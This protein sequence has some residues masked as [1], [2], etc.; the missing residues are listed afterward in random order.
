MQ[1]RHND[2]VITDAIAD[3]PEGLGDDCD[4]LAAPEPQLTP[5][6]MDTLNVDLWDSCF[7]WHGCRSQGPIEQAS[8]LEATHPVVTLP[9]TV[10]NPLL[11]MPG[12][13]EGLY[14]DWS[15]ARAG[16]AVLVPNRFLSASSFHTGYTPSWTH[17]D[18]I[19][20]GVNLGSGRKMII[21]NLG[22]CAKELH[23]EENDVRVA[24]GPQETA[25]GSEGGHG[26]GWDHVQ[27]CQGSNA[28]VAPLAD[29]HMNV[30]EP[31]GTQDS[32]ARTAF[33]RVS[34]CLPCCPPL[35]FLCMTI[36]EMCDE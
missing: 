5:G 1:Q 28:V 13:L 24:R 8:D 30:E 27:H 26:Y 7:R 12:H 18:V 2:V 31:G 14:T 19:G 35:P 34:S 29:A 15:V 17:G 25:I 11:G 22:R 3:L 21:V 9:V 10:A 20:E 32:T 16:W 4:N 36:R 6:S 23:M 33:P